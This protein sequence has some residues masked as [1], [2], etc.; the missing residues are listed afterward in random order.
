MGK[1]DGDV[2]KLV[3]DGLSN[4]AYWRLFCKASAHGRSVGEEIVAGL[5]AESVEVPP[6]ADARLAAARR[7][8]Q[9]I[10][11]RSEAS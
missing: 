9:L 6:D 4:A 5:N 1:R 7:I 8:R 10:A 3:L 2:V 11:A